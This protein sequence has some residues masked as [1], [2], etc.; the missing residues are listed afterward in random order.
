MKRW[1]P[2]G[3]RVPARVAWMFGD[4]LLASA[5]NFGFLAVAANALSPREFGVL[6][7]TYTVVVF[8]NQLLE[9][10][11]AEPLLVR[12]TSG[13]T[14]DA[15]SAVAT[16]TLVIGSALGVGWV[17]LAWSSSHGSA[18]LVGAAFC[19]PWL[20]VQNALRYA[21][22]AADR[23]A[24][25]FVSDLSWLALQAPLALWVLLHPGVSRDAV[26]FGWAAPGA[27]SCLPL[28]LGRRCRISIRAA[29]EF[30]RSAGDLSRAYVAESLVFALNI[31]GIYFVVGFVSDVSQAGALRAAQSLFGPLSVVYSLIRTVGIAELGKAG[32]D[33]AL[34]ARRAILVS[35]AAVAMSGAYCGTLLL[36]PDRIGTF[37]FSSLWLSASVLVAPL[38]V[39]SIFVGAGTAT[40]AALR[41]AELVRATVTARIGSALFSFMVVIGS[42]AWWG[43]RGAAWGVAF[44]AAISWMWFEFVLRRPHVDVRTA[45]GESRR[46][47]GVRL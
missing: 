44:A 40:V 2:S 35:V 33:R 12:A 24:L 42:A 1:G 29:H 47:A 20:L 32:R 22:V 8:A 30:A 34:L 14:K 23:A 26:V 16:I 21:A 31:H 27:V 46:F 11:I 17:A 19:V 39:R 5:S 25:A 6:T 15:P 18:A 41:A 43:A 4:Q 38:A 45:T 37:F 9:A 7:L 36:M 3:V 13:L 28:G 10:A